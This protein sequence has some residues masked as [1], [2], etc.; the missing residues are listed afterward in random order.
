[1]L[2]SI[3]RLSR[4][5]YYHGQFADANVAVSVGKEIEYLQYRAEGAC[6]VRIDKEVIDA[7]P[8]PAQ[9]EEHFRAGPEPVVE[10][11]IHLTGTHV[12]WI[13]VT[14]DTLTQASREF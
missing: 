2:G 11:W 9:D 3:R 12:G 8:C 4:E 5:D 6:F 14:E 10:W 1:M 7:D 13:E